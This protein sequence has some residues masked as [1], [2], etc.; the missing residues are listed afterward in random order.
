MNQSFNAHSSYQTSLFLRSQFNWNQEEVFVL[1]LNSQLRLIAL[2]LIFRGCID[3]CPFHPRDIFFKL[4]E[5]KASQF[6]ISHN[7]PTGEALPSEQDL[8]LTKNLFQLSELMMIPLI[9]HIIL[10]NESY[11]SFAEKKKLSFKTKK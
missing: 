3:H 4:I 9:D 11:Y 7:H 5:R 2:D 6:I 1:S 8:S 10:S